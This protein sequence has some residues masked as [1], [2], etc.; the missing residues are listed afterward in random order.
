[1]TKGKLGTG[2]N[3]VAWN[4]RIWV[5]VGWGEP[6]AVYSTDGII[7]NNTNIIDSTQYKDA[8]HIYIK[9]N[10]YIGM[11]QNGSL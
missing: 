8:T 2:G 6:A 1:M 5:A 11:E 10:L 3:S 4:G 7:W 9:P